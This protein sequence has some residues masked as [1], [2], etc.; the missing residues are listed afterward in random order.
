MARIPSEIARQVRRLQ[1][2][3][4]RTADALLAGAYASAFH[5]AGR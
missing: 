1:L 4:R 3:T 2:R 5:G